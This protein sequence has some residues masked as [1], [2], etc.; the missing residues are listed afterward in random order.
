M[1]SSVRHQLG[2]AA[3]AA[4]IFF[5]NLGVP[6]LW[7]DDEPRNAQCAREMLA[8]GDLVV[9]TFNQELRTD[10]P[11]LLYWLMMAAYR[12]LGDDEFSARF[13]SAL[14]AVGTSLATYHL[15]RSLFR[16][17]VGCWAGLMMA[18]S[19]MFG[20]TGRAATP[21]SL[22]ILCTT[23]GLLGYV[24]WAR[25]AAST[26][27]QGGCDRWAT[28]RH[29]P[30]F[31]ALGLAV[32]AK[33]PVG[34][35]LPLGAI[36][37]YLWSLEE[38]PPALR[39][40]QRLLGWCQPLPWLRSVWRARP[41]AAILVVA[42]I[43]LP[44]YVVV[45]MQTEGQWLRG[46]LGKHNLDRFLAPME[47]HGGPFFFYLPAIVIGFFPWSIFLPLALGNLVR[48]IRARQPSA[49][50][51]RFL[52]AWA[53]T[54]VVFFSLAGTKLPSYVLPA[55]PALAI[56]T[57]AFLDDWIAHRAEPPLGWLRAAW[58]SLPLVGLGLVVALP[59]LARQF[60]P[61]EGALAL[62]GLIPLLGGAMAWYQAERRQRLPA[63]A[64]LAATA[65]LFSVGLFG[66]AAVRVSQYHNS[67]ALVA[68]AARLGMPGATISTYRYTV[69][70]LVYYAQR[71][72]PALNQDDQVRKL[73]DRD[74][75]ALVIT[76]HKAWERLQAKLPPGVRVLERQP[77]FLK[78]EEV[79]IVGRQG[80][81]PPP[82]AGDRQ[83]VEPQPWK[84]GSQPRERR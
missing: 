66:F 82:V 41:L 45:G 42:A 7:D 84:L 17:A 68:G 9:P 74:P 65:V 6:R 58:A 22:L 25:P 54:Y 10:K 3:V 20:V 14:C 18:S 15:G 60:L 19:L 13:W 33:G 59:I 55:Y 67:P 53:G 35:V 38:T 36:V 76:T 78:R 62:V 29:L 83:H 75:Q 32:L 49:D 11:V 8:R 63:L 79:V 26:S 57:A 37:V 48:A 69:P 61:G 2:I 64:T 27:R 1:S 51:F 39:W 72:I 56:L 70:S 12:T 50:S 71:R 46:F 5:T 30:C 47:R 31:A 43:A 44:W 21:D 80:S 16:P 4:L 24:A 73:L 52:A 34:V 23:I 40:R 81:G 28:L 77:R